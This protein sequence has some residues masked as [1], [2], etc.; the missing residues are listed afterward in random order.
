[1]V[2]L[3]WKPYA[4]CSMA[5]RQPPVLSACRSVLS[6]MPA[7][8]NTE[9]FGAQGTTDI[10]VPLPL[11]YSDCQSVTRS[12]CFISSSADLFYSGFWLHN[13]SIDNRSASTG[14]LVRH[15]DLCCVDSSN[16]CEIS[17][18]GRFNW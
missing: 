4:D 7:S 13:R 18:R 10:D 12:F 11:K 9:T 5:E 16:V 8:S 6:N 17:S 15:V 14:Q 3:Q 1:M 2:I